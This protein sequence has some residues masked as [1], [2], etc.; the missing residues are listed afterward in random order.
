MNIFKN[1]IARIWALWGLVIF[2]ITF[3]IFF[4]P[5]MISNLYRDEKKGQ[6]YFMDVSRLWM[7]IWLFLIGCPVT[8]TGKRNF[9]KGKVYVVVYNHNAL[10]D[11]PLSAPYVPGP[12]KTIAKASFA[13]VPVFGSFYKRG[14]VLVDRKNEISRVR[15][16]EAMKK[17]L[18][19]GMHMCIYPEGARNRTNKPLKPFF[20]GAFK[21]A[22]DAQKDI[23]PVI[24][25]GTKR[26]MPV[27]KFFYL[28][29][30]K[31]NMHFLPA[32][33]SENIEVKSLKEKVYHQMLEFYTR[34][35]QS[36]VNG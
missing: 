28:L 25:T 22:I 12:N 26:A 21:L 29:P 17:T 36:N 10:L 3:L 33:S 27:H 31:L 32:V 13:K 11:A 6:V 7:N 18:R 1:I 24:I 34:E 23:I 5:S 16:Y 20:D 9:I 35:E 19:N 2:I 4:L 15:S 14:A 8:V 30:T